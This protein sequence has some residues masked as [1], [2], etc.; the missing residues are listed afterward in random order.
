[1]KRTRANWVL[2]SSLASLLA[3]CAAHVDL[4]A[5]PAMAPMEARVDAYNQLRGLSYHET[6]TTTYGS[7]GASSTSHSADYMQLANGTRVY[8]PEDVLP[9]VAEDSAPARSAVA[10]ESKRGTAHLLTLGAVLSVA[11]GVA[12]ALIPIATSK[13]GDVNGTP[14]LV[15]LG[16]GILGGA[17]FG[18]AAHFVSESAQDEAATTYET[19][20]IGLRSRLGLCGGDGSPVDCRR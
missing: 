1:M 11:A 4:S 17:G 20:D 3:G 15:G 14:V 10:S 18:I 19:Y 16:L 5:P 2:S 13:E 8:F 7:L 12:L 9:V 6:T